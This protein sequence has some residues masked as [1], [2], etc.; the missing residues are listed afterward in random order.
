[1]EEV[2]VEFSSFGII[3]LSAVKGSLS[4]ENTL[5]LGDSFLAWASA[6]KLLPETIE[7]NHDL[8][9]ARLFPLLHSVE[10]MGKVLRW[11]TTD[12]TYAEGCTL[13]KHWRKPSRE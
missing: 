5:F 3:I 2:V 12:P 4:D 7:G 6:R 10:Q 13:W 11:M 1:M 8:Q 9:S